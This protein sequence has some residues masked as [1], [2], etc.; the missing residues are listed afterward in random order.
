MA[1]IYYLMET[2]SCV[3][4]YLYNPFIHFKLHPSKKLLDIGQAAI[5]ISIGQLKQM[6]YTEVKSC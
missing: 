5:I 2:F 6:K 4:T 1:T 3:A